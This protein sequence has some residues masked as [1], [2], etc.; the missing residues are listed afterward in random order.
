MQSEKEVILIIDPFSTG[1]LYAP[2]FKTLGYKCFAILSSAT[3]PQRFVTAFTGDGFEYDQLFSV[4]DALEHFLPSQVAAVVAGN[5]LGVE[6]AD[7]VAAFFD[8]PGNDPQ[9]S[10]LRRD[11]HQMQQALVHHNLRSIPTTLIENAADIETR[12]AT[13]PPVAQFVLKPVNSFMTDGVE[14]ASS[15]EEL[16]ERLRAAPWGAPNS[17]GEINKGFLVQ[18]FISGPE[19]VVDMVVSGNTIAVASLC[20][21]SKGEHNGARFVYQGLEVLDPEAEAYQELIEYAKACTQAL[22]IQFGP[23]H[24]ELILSDEGPVMIEAGARL[25]G[26]VAPSLF[27]ECYAPD[28]L[29]MAVDL[30]T[31]LKPKAAPSKKIRDGRIV[32]LINRVAGATLQI[33]LTK[34]GQLKALNAYKGHKLFVG[35]EPLPLTIDLATCPGIVWLAHEQVARINAD[36]MAVRGV[37]E[38]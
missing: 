31:G 2:M 7:R 33:D 30:Y 10:G 32:F 3:V 34:V 25:H 11:K 6:V 16:A 1:A 15:R 22:D 37:I 5:E 38:G 27:M 35:D 20:K 8:V 29:G 9:T 12:L 28:L 4:E 36:E 24:M 21:Y 26:G 13:L 19:Y 14:F 23:V 18:R 17:M